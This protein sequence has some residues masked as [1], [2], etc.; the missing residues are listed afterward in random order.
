M[1]DAAILL[2]EFL[3]GLG[4]HA[5]AAWNVVGRVAHEAQDVDDLQGIGDA[6]FCLDFINAQHLVLAGVVDFGVFVHQLSEVLV[7]GHHVGHETRRRGFLREGAY[8]I[9]GLKAR[10][11][12]DGDAVGLENALDVG[13]RHLDALGCLVAVGL[14]LLIGLM[15]EGLAFGVEAHGDVRGILALE[16]VLQSV[17]KAENGAG[18]DAAF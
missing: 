2:H 13:H 15:P 18:V 8:H 11:L 14:V 17:D 10:H 3:S 7:A 1:L 16:Q 5:G 12:E 9:V 4:A 6:V